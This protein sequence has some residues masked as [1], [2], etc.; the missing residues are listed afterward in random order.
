MTD[1]YRPIA[2]KLN[3]HESKAAKKIIAALSNSFHE[4][5]GALIDEWDYSA[6][7]HGELLIGG[8]VDG[9]SFEVTLRIVDMMLDPL[10]DEDDEEEE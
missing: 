5:D 8:R 1:D 10:Y 3:E 2:L 9:E 7:E 6:G 4:A